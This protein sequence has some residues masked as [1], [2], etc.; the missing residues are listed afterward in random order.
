M[1]AVL[2][3]RAHGPGRDQVEADNVGSGS[4]PCQ[5]LRRP[6]GARRGRHDNAVTGSCD[7]ITQL[8]PGTKFRLRVVDG[9]A[10]AVVS[11]GGGR[12]APAT[13]GCRRV[14][15]EREVTMHT[16]SRRRARTHVP[17]IGRGRRACRRGRDRRRRRPCS[18]ARG[19]ASTRKLR[20]SRRPR[21]LD[22][23]AGR[24]PGAGPPGA[25]GAAARADRGHVALPGY[26]LLVRPGSP[27]RSR[28]AGAEAR[29]ADAVRDG[30]G[31]EFAE[32][33]AGYDQAVATAVASVR[34]RTTSPA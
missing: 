8:G 13:R 14:D 7:P 31:A 10:H 26:A 22:G 25:A 12:C 20:T 19:P 23:A 17:A 1:L 29:I 24:L 28:V 11:D 4:N 33:F 27:H 5:G 21:L 16:V 34:S 32:A 6:T 9:A 15:R 30:D 18:G 2:A 3:Q